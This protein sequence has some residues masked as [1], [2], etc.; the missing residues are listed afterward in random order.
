MQGTMSLKFIIVVL[1]CDEN[2]TVREKLSTEFMI[3]PLNP[4]LIPICYLLALLG[5]HKFLHVSRIRVNK[6]S[7]PYCSFLYRWAKS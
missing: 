4:E 2:R 5:A 6:A 3:N 1:K 7:Y